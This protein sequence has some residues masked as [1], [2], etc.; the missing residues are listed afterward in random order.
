MKKAVSWLL[1]WGGIAFLVW[2]IAFRPEQASNLTS[3]IAGFFAAIGQGFADFLSS[4]PFL[5]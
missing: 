5:S 3:K 2:F 4:L 1:T